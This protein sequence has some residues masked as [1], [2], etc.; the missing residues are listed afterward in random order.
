MKYTRDV[1]VAV[2]VG[3]LGSGCATITRVAP[4]L[5]RDWEPYH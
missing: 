5:E 2:L 1:T 3:V 4:Y